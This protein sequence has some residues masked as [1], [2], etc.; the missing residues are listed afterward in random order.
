MSVRKIVWLL[1]PVLLSVMFFS[2]CERTPVATPTQVPT[3]PLPTRNAATLALST[4]VSTCI[5]SFYF[6]EW[7]DFEDGTLLKPGETFVK[8][9]EI[10]NNGSCNWNAG[11]KLRFISGDQMGAPDVV[12]LPQAAVGKRGIIT[13]TFIAPEV[14]G[15]YRSSWKAFNG[16]NQSFGNTLFADIVVEGVAPTDESGDAGYVAP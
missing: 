15:S 9:W 7:E 6:T 12:A 16:Y 5:D 4:K 3:A 14:P 11:Y 2:A 8:E 1:L 10:V 13:V